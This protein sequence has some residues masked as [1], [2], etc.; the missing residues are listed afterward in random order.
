MIMSDVDAAR[1]QS[2]AVSQ[3]QQQFDAQQLQKNEENHEVNSL[4][5]T[6]KDAIQ[7]SKM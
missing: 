2:D 1:G 4:F 3:R 6:A 5:A 7:Q